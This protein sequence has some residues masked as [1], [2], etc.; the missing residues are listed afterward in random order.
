MLLSSILHYLL[1]G[2]V[3][4]VY[5]YI[6]RNELSAQYIKEMKVTVLSVST[7]LWPFLPQVYPPLF[8][9]SKLNLKGKLIYF[10]LPIV[11]ITCYVLFS[12]YVIHYNPSLNQIFNTF[13]LYGTLVLLVWGLTALKYNSVKHK[14]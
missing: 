12:L 4:I 2:I 7:L 5:D 6:H 10:V 3:P 1:I 14:K 9:W 13:G 11:S 8:I